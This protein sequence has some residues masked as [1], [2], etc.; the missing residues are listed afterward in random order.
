MDRLV[1]GLINGTAAAANGAG[2]ETVDDVR[3]FPK[4]LACFTPEVAA[5]AAGLKTFLS[6]HVY[7]SSRL[8][9]ERKRSTL[10]IAR[11]FEHFLQHPDCLPRS[12]RESAQ[13]T[14]LHRVVCDYIAGMTDGYFLRC[15]FEQ[16][17]DTA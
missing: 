5:L 8:R 17:L 1:A 9:S 14:P 6:G 15:Y 7:S 13:K 11:L 16:K 2:V 3:A 4:R 12:F 10:K